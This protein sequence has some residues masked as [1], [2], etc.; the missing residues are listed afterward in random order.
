MS[1]TAS[2]RRFEK[3]AADLGE[4]RSSDT[5]RFTQMWKRCAVAGSVRSMHVLAHGDWTR[6]RTNIRVSLR[7]TTTLAVWHVLLVQSISGWWS[8][9]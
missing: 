8:K 1:K 7:C 9:V 3:R 4:L 6:P 2:Q 5:P